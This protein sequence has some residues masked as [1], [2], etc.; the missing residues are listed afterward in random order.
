LTGIAADECGKGSPGDPDASVPDKK[1][2]L[3]VS[4][5]SATG[6]FTATNYMNTNYQVESG[7]MSLGDG[8]VHA[9]YRVHPPTTKAGSFVASS[10]LVYINTDA[11]D[12][13]HT[14]TEGARGVQIRRPPPGPDAAKVTQGKTLAT[15]DGY[16]NTGIVVHDI[17]A[18][19]V[20]FVTPA[21][22]SFPV[23]TTAYLG[24][25]K[26][27]EC[28][29][30]IADES[31]TADRRLAIV[32]SNRNKQ[33]PQKFQCFPPPAY[34]HQQYRVDT[35]EVKVSDGRSYPAFLVHPPA[36]R[37]TSFVAGYQLIYLEVPAGHAVYTVTA[38]EDGG[39]LI[40]EHLSGQWLAQRLAE[41]KTY[42]HLDGLTN[43]GI[44]V[45]QPKTATVIFLAPR[46]AR[47]SK[48]NE[49]SDT[50]QGAC[51]AS[52]SSLGYSIQVKKFAVPGVPIDVARAFRQKTAGI[53][54]V[55]FAGK[56][57][58]PIS[59]RDRKEGVLWRDVKDQDY[60]CPNIPQC[61]DMLSSNVYM[62]WFDEDLNSASTVRIH[63]L[64][65]EG[66]E[67]LYAAASDGQDGIVLITATNSNKT[68]R[69]IKLRSD[70]GLVV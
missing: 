10:M 38:D 35:G 48:W 32:N 63:T 40:T 16:D 68:V 18:P 43:T 62:T 37:A 21:S 59:R 19:I 7:Q 61:G 51:L 64:A 49:F 2:A 24:N 15:L 3:V 57:F 58:F 31:R 1:L 39:Q 65:G 36:I 23:P 41:N 42:A 53:A 17:T 56:A 13:V 5:Y 70:T 26:A 4:K 30:L 11:G 9:A 29:N 55:G 6:C 47:L 54:G 34:M 60:K 33:V 27:T 12:Q 66:D 46:G 28:K 69:V 8:T 44:D 45:A 52:N 20:L 25:G 67:Q 14:L 22:Y 50:V